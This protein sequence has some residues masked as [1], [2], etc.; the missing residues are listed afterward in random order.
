MIITPQ[1]GFVTFLGCDHSDKTQTCWAALDTE[2]TLQL[3][4]VTVLVSMLV[5]SFQVFS[6]S[7]FPFKTPHSWYL[8]GFNLIQRVVVQYLS[9]LSVSLFVDDDCILS[10]FAFFVRFCCCKGLNVS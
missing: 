7:M 4:A 6:Y 5:I 10:G 8:S 2:C 3:R 1:S 9:V